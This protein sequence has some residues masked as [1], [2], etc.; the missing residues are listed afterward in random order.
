M[1]PQVIENWK[2]YARNPSP[3]KKNMTGGPLEKEIRSF[4][5]EELSS[6][7]ALVPEK[8]RKFKVWN[9]VNIIADCLVKMVGKP[10]SLVSVKS[11]IGPT[12][13]RETF[14][15]AYFSKTWRGQKN[16]RVFMIELQPPK[17]HLRSLVAACSPYIDGVYSI[18]GTPHFD[19]LLEELKRIYGEGV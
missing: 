14:G 16:M 9:D 11:W 8:G 7:N 1:L 6:L 18:S 17:M 5:R 4:V 12:Q 10:T 13:L 19:E 2:A 3:G 15:Y